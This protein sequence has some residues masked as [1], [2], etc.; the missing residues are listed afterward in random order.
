PP[1]GRGPPRASPPA[2]DP[3][4]VRPFGPHRRPR[5][6]VADNPACEHDLA[7]PG[8]A[9]PAVQR[10]PAMVERLG[11]PRPDE[12]RRGGLGDSGRLVPGAGISLLRRRTGSH[13]APSAVASMTTTAP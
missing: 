2:V 12:R 7:R 10:S 6:G 1:G 9:R 3:G 11:S 8:P 13:G 4:G 5:G